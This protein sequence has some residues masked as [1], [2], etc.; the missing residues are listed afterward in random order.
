MASEPPVP[1]TTLMPAPTPVGPPGPAN[2]PKPIANPLV[3][4]GKP[5]K[6]HSLARFAKENALVDGQYRTYAGC[7]RAGTPT[8]NEPAWAAL[9][10]GKS[11]KKLLLVWSDGGSYNF[12]ETT[13]GAP[14]DYRIEVS[15]DSSDG[16]NGSWKTVATVKDNHFHARG[17]SFAFEGQSWVKLILLRAPDNSPNGLGIDELELFDLSAGG[18]D[19]WFFMGDSITAFLFDRESTQHQPS[20]PE[21]VHG[22]NP[23]FYP[24]IINAGIG[25][26][27]SSHGLAH[28]DEWLSVA[29]DFK[30]WGIGYGTNDA[31]GNTE[32]AG[33]FEQ[34]MDAIA[35]RV[36]AAG[37]VPIFAKIPY[38]AD[39]GHAHVDAFNAALE[40]VSKKYGLASGPDLYSWFRQNPDQL[41]D[42]LHPG[43]DKLH[44]PKNGIVEANRL[45]WEAT[46]WLYAP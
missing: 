4:R 3:S 16:E 7:W 44:P 45:W 13:Y 35:K 23:R 14:A 32:S 40:R 31:A 33:P 34:N 36:L 10:V 25:G 20:F 27:N 11:F 24:A 38:A 5:V 9:N 12:N 17:H 43:E 30:Y 42:K 19:S 41:V 8:P 2:V 37:H 6:G 46:R 15:A 29:P 1:V 22:A 26:E 18:T 28:L 39:G 21:L